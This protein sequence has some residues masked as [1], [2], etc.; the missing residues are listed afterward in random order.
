LPTGAGGIQALAGAF[1]DELAGDYVDTGLLSSILRAT[2]RPL[3]LRLL[4]RTRGSRHD[5]TGLPPRSRGQRARY[6][7]DPVADPSSDGA[8]SDPG[9][10]GGSDAG[11]ICRD[12]GGDLE[13]GDRG[14]FYRKATKLTHSARRR[15]VSGVTSHY[16]VEPDTAQLLQLGGMG[17]T[18]E[19][20]NER[21]AGRAAAMR[22]RLDARR[23]IPP[24]L[25]RRE[26]EVTF[27]LRGTIGVQV[28]HEEFEAPPG[29]LVVGPKDLF[30]AYWSP[31]HDPVEFLTFITPGGFEHFFEEF[32]SAFDSVNS[33]GVDPSE[34]A[35][36]RATLA[37]HYGLEHS[38]E[39][40][41][42]VR[43]RHG[44]RALGE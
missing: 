17:L 43:E 20:P 35:A 4:P 2:D 26:D 10:E 11:G 31:G 18:V 15:T 19:V 34:V 9:A 44:L 8:G 41:D 33:E 40:L 30:H 7:A 32:H 38:R 12:W 25:H 21:L 37:D 3:L 27:V 23:V 36:R 6:T 28:G 29:S 13:G 42:A 22:I 16:L 24:H 14:G 5:R 1:D 39:R